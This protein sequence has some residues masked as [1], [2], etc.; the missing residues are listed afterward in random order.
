MT[1][2]LAD[3]SGPIRY[4]VV[5]PDLAQHRLRIEARFP[6]GMLAGDRTTLAL[7]VW[8][9]GSYKVRDYSKSLSDVRLLQPEGARLV[10]TA[11]NRWTI[12][13]DLP[14]DQPV[15]VSYQVYGHELTVRTNYFT[16]DLSLL[17]GAA[18]FLAPA[19][20][21]EGRLENLTFEVQFPD[22]TRPVS[23]A[24]AQTAS[25]PLTF[26]AKGF[27]QL[28]DSPI[29]FGDLEQ[30]DFVVADVPHRLVQ[31]GDRRYWELA[32]SLKDTAKVI[33]TVRQFWGDL[34]YEKYLILNLITET[35]GGL[36]H[37][38][39]T[40]LM[41]SR[42]ATRDREKYLE[43][44]SLV[45][46]EHFHVWNVKRLRPKVLG[47]FDY[48]KEVLT[49]SLW[50]AEGITSYYDDLLVRRAGLSS[51]T[52]YLKALSGQLNTLANT[53]GRRSLP[54]SEASRDAWI[55]RYQPTPNSPN[56]D[57]SYY[58]KGAVVA[59][60]LDTELRQLSGGK[61]TL[62]QVM[63]TAYREFP[64][65]YEES[66]FRDLVKRLAGRDLSP[67]FDRA[68][69]STEELDLQRALDYWGLE[70]TPDDKKAAA[71]PA[72][73]LTMAADGRTVE[74]VLAGSPAAGAGVAPGDELLAVD[75][76]RVPSSGPQTIVKHLR[77]GSTVPLTLAR[78][79]KVR[80]LPVT[81]QPP[82]APKRTLRIKDDNGSAR[83]RREAWLGADIATP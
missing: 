58:T 14:A 37:L 39:S 18:T 56:D 54:L 8:T 7:P 50:I 35:R 26:E 71:Q 10:K 81:L 68:V 22:V 66:Q 47:P 53:P 16:P 49:P 59:W 1:P 12:E 57:V 33:D 43:W 17:I 28:V 61:V 63:R 19:P 27:D 74:S 80:E 24:L 21:D 29:L 79:G 41:T 45:C 76:V 78:L 75:G 3:P 62:D 44:L 51:H 4:T 23:T 11:K 60:L 9:P 5:T 20:L 72:L 32:D 82:P 48:E 31:A 13:G 55:R 40:V 36:E 67:F 65:G 64:D 15:V 25:S 77:V 69:D 52:E 70:W 73:G 42:F 34:P 6:A 30:H 38:E 2:C 46:H 83:A